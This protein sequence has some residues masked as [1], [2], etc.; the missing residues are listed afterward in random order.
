M[1]SVLDAI[2]RSLVTCIFVVCCLC[3]AVT[4][5]DTSRPA[6]VRSGPVVVYSKADTRSTRVLT[7][8]G[9]DV[10]FV[11]AELVDGNERWCAINN[12]SRMFIGFVICSQIESRTNHPKKQKTA[13]P[14]ADRSIGHG[15][16]EA[17]AVDG[18]DVM[19]PDAGQRAVGKAGS[20]D[21]TAKATNRKG[22]AE[23][24]DAKPGTIRNGLI[25]CFVFVA[26]FL[27]VFSSAYLLRR[28][29][30]KVTVEKRYEEAADAG[31]SDLSQVTTA[32]AA[33]EMSGPVEASRAVRVEEA[34]SKIR[35]A[36]SSG[37]GRL[38]KCQLCG[39]I[40]IL[41]YDIKCIN[42][43]ANISYYIEVEQK[44]IKPENPASHDRH[45]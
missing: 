4:G 24:N 34:R 26:V 39:T 5:A 27:V 9:D 38:V 40:Q 17:P 32:S 36:G 42:C 37:I 8:S 25:V 18:K 10:F 14:S 13:R 11:Q 12:S 29:R 31:T 6:K 1:N 19:K 21:D 22:I 35:K 30:I 3:S 45:R 7:L 16:S 15:S 44:A 33:E 23:G 2:R 43:R 28:Y 20:P 41:A